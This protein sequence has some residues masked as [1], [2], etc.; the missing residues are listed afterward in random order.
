MGKNVVPNLE[1]LKKK[2]GVWGG[3]ALEGA[4]S[5]SGSKIENISLQFHDQRSSRVR[6]PAA[7]KFLGA[8]GLGACVGSV[9]E[10]FEAAK[11]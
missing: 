10:Y 3:A 7:N 9:R 4:L 8:Y 1:L 5:K 2:R 6:N 11:H